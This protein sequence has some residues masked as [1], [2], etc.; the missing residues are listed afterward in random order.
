MEKAL[1]TARELTQQFE[2]IREAERRMA[3]EPIRD[4]KIEDFIAGLGVLE[5]W[6]KEGTI[7]VPIEAAALRLKDLSTDMRLYMGPSAQDAMYHFISRLMTTCCTR[8][9]NIL[10][11]HHLV[12]AT[13]S[14]IIGEMRGR[15]RATLSDQLQVIPD[16]HRDSSF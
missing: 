4:I 1:P 13:V 7:D 16:T 2:A 8:L 6:E 15:S 9:G 10:N 3:F 5:I 11:V 12:N 14:T